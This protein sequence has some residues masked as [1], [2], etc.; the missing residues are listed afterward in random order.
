MSD[1]QIRRSAALVRILSMDSTHRLPYNH[2]IGFR[3]AET[4]EAHGF[5]FRLCLSVTLAF[6]VREKRMLQ[7]GESRSK[8]ASTQSHDRPARWLLWDH[9]PWR[10]QMYKSENLA[11]VLNIGT[12]TGPCRLFLDA[13]FGY[14]ARFRSA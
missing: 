7:Y 3:D 14:T 9:K 2:S 1:P 4:W 12:A 5:N 10:P 6:I 11:S 13:L 8:P